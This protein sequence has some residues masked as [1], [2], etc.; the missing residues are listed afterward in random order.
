MSSSAH[1]FHSDPTVRIMPDDSN[2][3]DIHDL[4]VP[5]INSLEESVT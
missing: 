3:Y 4:L 5:A 2:Y 1:F